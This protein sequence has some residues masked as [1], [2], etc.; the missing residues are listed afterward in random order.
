[1]G[2]E[3]LRIWRAVGLRSAIAYGLNIVGRVTCRS[4]RYA[5]ALELLGQARDLNHEIGDEP[6]E[7][8]SDVR[9]AECLAMQGRASEALELATE[10]LARSETLGGP[11]TPQLQRVR[12]CALA[13]LGRLSEAREALEE[14]V[15]GA[16]GREA[17][18]EE[19]L[20]L[21]GLARIGAI[22]GS[23][24][25]PE[26]EARYRAIFERL[27]VVA[28]PMIP[29]GEA[30][31]PSA[32]RGPRARKPTV[33]PSLLERVSRVHPDGDVDLVR[34]RAPRWVARPGRQELLGH[35]RCGG[36][37]AARRIPTQKSIPPIVLIDRRA[38]SPRRER[39][40]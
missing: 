37:V 34:A 21:Q 7:L 24:D 3:A 40:G 30:P 10:A 31:G 13:Q 29:I 6:E 27:G 8:E 9:I 36:V 22:E 12:G 39:R 16:R 26:L 4:G 28:A 17:E 2:R 32:P 33:L 23:S 14:S 38:A 18:Y 5:E 11:A 19:A 25:A 1:M 35:A 20:A 15:A